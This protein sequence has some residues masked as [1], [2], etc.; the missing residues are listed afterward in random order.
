M[1]CIMHMLATLPFGTEV[2]FICGDGFGQDNRVWSG[3]WEWGCWLSRTG[4]CNMQPP[5]LTLCFIISVMKPHRLGGSSQDDSLYAT[6]A[7]SGFGQNKA[8]GI[9]LK[10]SQ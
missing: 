4:P 6:N 10:L 8:Q 9:P 3:Q 2:S 7:F 5:G 1:A